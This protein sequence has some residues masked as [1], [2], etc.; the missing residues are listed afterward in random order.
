[1]KKRLFYLLLSAFWLPAQASQVLVTIG[2]SGQVTEQELEA[3]MHAAPFATQF[4]AMDEQNQAYLRGD[5]LLRLA[6]AEALY[7]EAIA[8]GIQQTP[9]FKQEIGNFA[10]TT[11]A[12][13]YLY[14]LRRQIT[15]P[16]DVDRQ[17]KLEFSGN[18]DA[19]TAA[20][21]AY[22][23]R[24]FAKA[25]QS[26]LKSL[27][28]QANVRTY[29]ERLNGQPSKDTLL[30]EGEAISIRYGDLLPDSNRDIARGVI[31]DKANEWIDLMLMART[32]QQQGEN[33]AAQLAEYGHDLAIRL[34]LA[35][36]EQNWIPDE[37]TLRDYFQR[38]PDIGYIPER[39]QIGQIV[40][41]TKKQAEQLRARI[42]A[43]ESLFELAGLYSI[44]PYGRQRLG[45][46]GWL[47]AGSAAPA[48]EQAIADLPNDRISEPVQTQ[49]GWHLI[50]IVDRKP[51]ERKHFAAIKDRVR[52]KLVAEKM[53]EYL[54]E[55]T[56]KYPL[57]WQ[58]AEHVERETM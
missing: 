17:F 53:S 25:K 8:T 11:L 27:R 52:Q 14:R 9:Q 39:R 2:D 46:M 38:H 1:M 47:S 56:E 57:Q 12:Q 50:M 22:I 18:S 34:L 42:A 4:P 26:A 5:M 13:R 24:R 29:F 32:A 28:E 48:I 23:A 58:I 16:D 31:E 44:D 37:Q 15:L 19:L 20:R 35:Q 33:I 6:R 7:Q 43:G 30:A 45:D 40:V 3:A 21:S 55:V 51:S 54:R 36:Q 49:Q 41:A 10:T